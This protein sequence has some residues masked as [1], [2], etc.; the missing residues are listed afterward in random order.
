MR[1]FKQ[2]KA[3]IKILK[4]LGFE[5]DEIRFILDNLHL[6]DF[7][8]DNNDTRFINH[9]SIDNIML[10]EFEGDPYM[11]GGFKDWIIAKNTDLSTGIIRALKSDDNYEI[12]GR[13]IISKGFLPRIL[14]NYVRVDGYGHHFNVYNG[15][16][17]KIKL[18][19]KEG[20]NV[21]KTTFI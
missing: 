16:G 10:E 19:D 17:V 3:N 6:D 20:E 7:T 13:H 5:K 12:L 11:V 8:L 4:R 18:Y 9:K 21:W 2:I 15:R 1:T 14:R